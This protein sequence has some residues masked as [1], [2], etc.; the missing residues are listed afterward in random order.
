MSLWWQD[1]H[2]KRQEKDLAELQSLIEAHFI[3]RK[4]E[5]EELIALVNRIV[6][7]STVKET[8]CFSL[9]QTTCDCLWLY[10]RNV[11]LR[12]QSSRGSGQRERR[13]GRP[14]L[15][16]GHRKLI[17]FMYKQQY[18]PTNFSSTWQTCCIQEEKERKE[19]EEQRKKHDEDAKKKKALSNMT[20]QYSAGQ[21][22]IPLPACQFEIEWTWNL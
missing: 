17:S 18:K 10:R 16:Y 7:V 6:S 1:I 11:V 12:E 8:S 19:Q 3:Q 2:R 20:Q 15:W 21:K 9:I 14:G 5:E 13:R 4:K 22:V